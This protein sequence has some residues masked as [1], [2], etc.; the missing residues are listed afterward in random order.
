[1]YDYLST[2]TPD[3]NSTMN[4]S[5]QE[6]VAEALVKNQIIHYF[7]DGSDRVIGLDDD[8]I[9]EVTLGWGKGISES[10]AGTILDFYADANK[11]NGMA[12]SFKWD[13]PTDGHSYVVRFKSALKRNWDYGKIAS[14]NSRY[15][16][17]DEITLKILGKV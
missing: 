9:F 4:V 11:A 6:I 3:Y 12:R 13:H 10:D 2:A 15:L 8:P 16:N 17:V 5:P 1:M 14:N 7:D